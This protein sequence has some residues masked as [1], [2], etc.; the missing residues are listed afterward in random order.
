M[1]VCRELDL[2]RVKGKNKPVK[3]IYEL[4]A[5]IEDKKEV[6]AAGRCF[7]GRT[8]GLPPRKVPGSL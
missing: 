6:G 1:V 4:I 5:P 2:I 7:R 8:E 3:A